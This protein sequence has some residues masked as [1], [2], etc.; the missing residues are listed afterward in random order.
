MNASRSDESC[1]SWL[2]RVLKNSAQ[3]EIALPSHLSR[4]LRANLWTAIQR[5]RPALAAL[6][7]EPHV[8]ELQEVFGGSICVEAS[9][10]Q[11]VLKGVRSESATPRKYT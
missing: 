11:I 4:E 10:L 9:D 5:Y 2:E 8:K 7:Q 3:S 1:R 6:L